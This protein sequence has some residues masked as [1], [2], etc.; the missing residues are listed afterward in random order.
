[1]NII[2]PSGIKAS[3]IVDSGRALALVQRYAKDQGAHIVDVGC[4]SG[5]FLS[6]LYA[7]GYMNVSGI[8]PVQYPAPRQFQIQSADICSERFPR[9][10]ASCDAITAWEVMEHLENPYFAMR[11][12]HRVLKPG[13]V[14]IFSMPNAFHWSNKIYFLFTG[15]FLR[16]NRKNDHR[17]IFTH[18]VLKKAYVRYFDLA[19]VAYSNPEFWQA[20]FQGPLRRLN[21]VFRKH[22]NR[23]FPNGQMFSHFIVYILKKR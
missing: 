10:D 6:Q 3:K 21:G 2:Q 16:W 17:T 8:E 11:E 9:Q 13:G 4:G 14:F 12:I 23:F 5:A 22:L 18:D 19:A 20:K 15:N 7:S 1:M